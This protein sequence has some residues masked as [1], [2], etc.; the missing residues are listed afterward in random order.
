M[1][2]VLT[3]GPALGIAG[4]MLLHEADIRREVGRPVTS[5]L[6]R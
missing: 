6:P 2:F 4:F 1:I 5:G 3:G